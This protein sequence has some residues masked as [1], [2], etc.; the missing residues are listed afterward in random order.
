[1][2]I[3]KFRVSYVLMVCLAWGLI[4]TAAK[5]F[6]KIVIGAIPSA[7][8]FFL[9]LWAASM[10]CVRRQYYKEG[11]TNVLNSFP[12][13]REDVCPDDVV[14]VGGHK[15]IRS[16]YI[17]Q[18]ALYITNNLYVFQTSQLKRDCLMDAGD[19]LSDLT[20]EAIDVAR[21]KRPMKTKER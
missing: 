19:P 16:K 9:M 5:L 1:M 21:G 17:E 8:I 10:L 6:A 2:R 18:A 15:Y 11:L 13:I 20:L 14:E 12:A 4:D 3:R 7:I